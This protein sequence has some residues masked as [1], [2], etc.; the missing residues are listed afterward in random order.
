MSLYRTMFG[1]YVRRRL[2]RELDGLW[3]RG[4]DDARAAV[5][6]GPVVFAATHVSW[7]DG[8]VLMPVDDALGRVGRVWMDAA[9][10]RRL[11]YLRPLGAMPI[12]GSSVGAL[13]RSARDAI[14]WLSGS[15]RALWVFPQGRHRP[16]WLRPL[17][18]APGAG[19][20]AARAGAQLVPVAI[21]YGF[22]DAPVPAVVVSFGRPVAADRLSDG[23]VA[24]LAAADALWTDGEAGFVPLVPSRARGTH[25][26]LP[27]RLLARVVSGG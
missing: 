23:I 17:A 26:S 27:A 15:G 20:V 1:A 12:D 25:Q 8:L 21:Q 10:L 7:W 11:P 14:G 13:R 22:R 4:L 16:T 18:L 9:N 24:E 2:G 6:R 5:A 3:V 19:W